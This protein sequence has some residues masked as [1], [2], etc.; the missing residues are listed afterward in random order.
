[1]N[2]PAIK[3]KVSKDVMKMVAQ[4]YDQ[5]A[6]QLLESARRM[7]EIP[8]AEIILLNWRQEK[9]FGSVQIIAP[10]YSEEIVYLSKTSKPLPEGL[11]D[12]IKEKAPEVMT[13]TADNE[14]DLRGRGHV[15]R[16]LEDRLTIM[17]P[18]QTNYMIKN[19]P[20][21]VEL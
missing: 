9:Y 20:T 11:A 3:G 7:T 5:V 12:S 4:N 8:K 16:K 18:E 15:L 21:V 1:M 17:T 14:L 2:N 13:L 10:K 19:P 6:R